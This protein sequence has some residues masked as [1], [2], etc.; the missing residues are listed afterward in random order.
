MGAVVAYIVMLGLMV[1]VAVTLLF[2]LRAIKL[3]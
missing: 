3:I 2:G 1:G